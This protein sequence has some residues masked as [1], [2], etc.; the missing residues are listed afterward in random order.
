MMSF[1]LWRTTFLTSSPCFSKNPCLIPTSSGKV[2]A[3]GMTLTEIGMPAFDFDGVA[4]RRTGEQ[5]RD[6]DGGDRR[7][8][9]PVPARA[10]AAVPAP[11][12]DVHAPFGSLLL[13]R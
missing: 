8:Q 6:E 11:D 12:G 5:R 10:D 7:E 9:D 3:I 13:L 2:F 1:P 4:A